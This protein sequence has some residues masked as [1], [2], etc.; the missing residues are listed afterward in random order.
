MSAP[1]DASAAPV[2]EQGVRTRA[3]NAMARTRAAVLD[4]ACRAVEK[5][6]A[7]KA[8][9]ADIASLAGIAKGTLYN[10]FRAKEAVYAAALDSGVRTLVSE[11]TVAARED[12][13]EALALAADRVGNHPALRRIAADE[14]AVLAGL[15]APA[16]TPLWGLARSGVRDVLTA[17]GSSTGSAGVDLVLRWVVSFVASPA[18]DATSQASLL[19]AGLGLPE[20]PAAAE[21]APQP[22]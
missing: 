16:D 22:E 5:H 13:V 4:G 19:V 9:M 18:T 3:G 6:G 2:R 1:V 21:S 17:A 15:V 20:R 7:R 11:C 10:H 14:P 12:L 8:T